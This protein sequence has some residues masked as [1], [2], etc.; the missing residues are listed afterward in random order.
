MIVNGVNKVK[1]KTVISV[2][3]VVALIAIAVTSLIK[4]NMEN[5]AAQQVKTAQEVVDAGGLKVGKEAPNFTLQTLDGKEVSLADY[6]GKK[7]MIN[8]WAT[9]C[10]PCRE[11]TPHL[12]NYYNE[13]AKE[14]NFE[15][16][17]INAMSTESK[18]EKVGQFIDEYKM[19]FP[20]LID[21]RGEL[22]KKYEVMNFP[23]SFFVNT[24]GIIQEKSYVLNEKQLAAIVDK[25]D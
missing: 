21:P 5:E 7:V 1:L 16:L 20:V 6:R 12:V 10:P 23:T 14:G 9:W 25:L 8:F 3:L 17:S 19:T 13:H 11:E 22:V 24:K 18:S 2:V 15:I 4:K